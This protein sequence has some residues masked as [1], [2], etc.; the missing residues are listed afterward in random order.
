VRPTSRSRTSQIIKVVA[1]ALD[2]A[3]G[4]LKKAVVG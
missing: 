2:A 1:K 4:L 3:E